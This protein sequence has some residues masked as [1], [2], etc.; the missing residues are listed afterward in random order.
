MI[1]TGSNVFFSCYD[2]FQSKDK[3]YILLEDNPSDYQYVKQTSSTG[4]CLFQWKRLTP[5]EYIDYA[6]NHGL[7]M[8]IV[9]F[10]TPEFVKEI[11]FTISDLK[12]LSPLCENLDVKH[13]YV[14]IIF[15]A[16][17]SNNDFILTDDQRLK[18]Y[19]FY[20]ETRK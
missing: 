6:L 17:I 14:K 7:A 2:D 12:Q 11:G 8:Q 15:E 1:L 18:A 3:D 16:Y 9:K 13:Q 4:F 20:K 5:Q 19:N 10:L